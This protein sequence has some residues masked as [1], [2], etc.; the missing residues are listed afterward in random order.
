MELEGQLP[1]GLLDLILVGLRRDAQH[2]VEVLAGGLGG[3]ARRVGLRFA[4]I[5][6][7]PEEADMRLAPSS[8]HSQK[9]DQSR[10]HWRFEHIITDEA[11]HAPHVNV[12]P[13]VATPPSGGR[14]ALI[15]ALR[16]IFKDASWGRAG[17]GG[18]DF[19]QRQRSLYNHWLSAQ[20]PG[21]V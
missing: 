5:L 1:V 8:H 6:R 15:S 3:Q 12:A 16:Y 18:A 10:R 4:A 7:R 11:E 9:S 13:R 14:N 17:G 21:C 2:L 20:E 19:P